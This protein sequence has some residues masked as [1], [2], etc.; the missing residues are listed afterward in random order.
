MFAICVV[1]DWKDNS[2]RLFITSHYKI[3]DIKSY[4]I[5]NDAFRTLKTDVW[6]HDYLKTKFTIFL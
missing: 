1:L 5:Y 6:R 4:V 3:Y 2:D